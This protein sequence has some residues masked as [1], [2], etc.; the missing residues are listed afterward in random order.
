MGKR[1]TKRSAARRRKRGR[2]DKGKGRAPAKSRCRD[3]GR[4]CSVPLYSYFR[5]SRPRCMACGG[6][7]DYLGTWDHSDRGSNGQQSEANADMCPKCAGPMVERLNRKR[8]TRFLG[9]RAY[10]KCT[11]TRPLSTTSDPTPSRPNGE[12]AF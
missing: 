11:G 9:C 7:L 2:S 4:E 6:S 5:A 12:A 1:A 10:P 8:G 3:C